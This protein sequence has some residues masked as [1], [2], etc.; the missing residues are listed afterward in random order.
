[1][2]RFLGVFLG[3]LILIAGIVALGTYWTFYQPLPNYN[4][5]LEQ[6]A[7]QQA[8]DIHWDSFGVP[9]IY[10]KNKHDLYY[11]LGYVHAQDRLWQMTVSQMAAE[12]RFAE[13]L[14]K[15]IGRAS[16]R[17]RVWF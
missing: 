9:H 8:V 10:A 17:G 5:T 15:E 2:K 12:G 6:P 7:L 1:M 3:L 13:F 14:G 16:C 11:S 4:A